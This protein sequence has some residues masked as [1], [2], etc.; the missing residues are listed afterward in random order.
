M[1]ILIVEDN[2]DSRMILKRTLESNGYTIE[3]ASNGVEALGLAKES[4]PDLIIS[5]ILMPEMDGFRLCYEVKHDEQLKKIPFVFYTATYT[6]PKDERLALALG[7]SRF[8]FKPAETEEF[9]NTIREVLEEYKEKRLPVP[10]KQLEEDIAIYRMYVDSLVR[11]LNEKVK[12]LQHSKEKYQTIVENIF[13]IIYT[14]TSEGIITFISPNI[15]LWGYSPEEIIGHNL[16]EFIHPDDVEHV[17]QDFQRTMTT[18]AE[19]PTVAR[20]RKKDGSYIYIEEYG[21]VLKKGDRII[22]ITGSI[23]DITK[24]RKAEEKVRKLS[25]AV[26]QSSSLIMITDTHGIIEYINPMFIKVTGYSPEEIIGKNATELGMQSSAQQKQMWETIITGSI[27]RGEF[28]NSKKNGEFYWEA[29]SISPVRNEEGIITHFIKVAEDI[30][31][32]KKMEDEIKKR[33]KELEE[34]YQ[35]AIGRELRMIE[36]KNEIEE[37][38]GELSK[39][40]K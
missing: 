19:F 12:D 27:W 40:K 5:D 38:K 35:L 1:K 3:E 34:F 21:K 6:D 32:K 20:L 33:V 25:R 37:L 4:P 9:L 11:K 8:I 23:R 13:D 14:V 36:L 39:Y 24:R 31:N 10:E 29:A 2:E 18:G 26:E 22:Q 28:Y 17:T 30:T 7:A 15:S 16:L